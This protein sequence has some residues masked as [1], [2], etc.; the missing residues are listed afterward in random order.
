MLC[1]IIYF[2][3]PLTKFIQSIVENRDIN[4]VNHRKEYWN[5]AGG[6][7]EA[8]HLR[9]GRVKLEWGDAKQK[10]IL[11]R[12]AQER[13]A[14]KTPHEERLTSQKRKKIRKLIKALEFGGMVICDL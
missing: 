13:I 4:I 10:N 9:L 14:K 12:L 8:A 7:T 1:D 2:F 6:T 5:I 11:A 3:L